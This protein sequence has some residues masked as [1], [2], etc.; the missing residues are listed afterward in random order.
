MERNKKLLGVQVIGWGVIAANVSGIVFNYCVPST[1]KMPFV[2]KVMSYVAM[3]AV[4]PSDFFFIYLK[5][6][7]SIHF[8]WIATTILCSFGILRLNKFAR[9]GFIV[10]NIVHIVILTQI[11]LRHLGSATFLDYFFKLYFNLV[12]SGSYVAFITIPEVRTQFIVGEKV[13]SLFLEGIKK[14]LLSTRLKEPSSQDAQGYF[15]LGIAYRRL[16]RYDDAVTALKKAVSIPP[17]KDSFYLSLGETYMKQKKYHEAIPA[18]TEAV[19]INPSHGEAYYH[20]GIAY[21]QEGCDK[22]AI[23][24]LEKVSPLQPNKAD[25]YQSL[26][27]SYQSVKRFQEALEAFQRSLELNP[28]DDYAYYQRG[29][30]FLRELGKA[31]EARDAFRHAIRLKPDRS[32]AHFQLGMACILLNR[33]KDALRAF[34]EVIRLDENNTE[35]HYQM[36]FVYAMIKDFDSARREYKF[37][38][39]V[40]ADLADTLSMVIR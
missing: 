14:I 30:I 28:D 8:Y 21:Q 20:L 11:V 16:G 3:A 24:A 23:A 31:E 39:N 6:V 40:D 5:D 25:V 22:E 18:F 19:R 33:Y 2:S 35:A 29:I 12:A 37:L 1:D 4:F 17:A 38:K 15:N 34:K 10:L 7:W 36:G 26:G 9:T 13:E 27:K 32:Q